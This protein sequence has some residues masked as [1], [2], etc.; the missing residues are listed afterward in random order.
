[1]PLACSNSEALD[2]H[3]TSGLLNAARLGGGVNRKHVYETMYTHDDNSTHL[4]RDQEKAE[5]Q[6]PDSLPKC[7]LK[8]D[9]AQ[10]SG[11]N[12]ARF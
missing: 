9:P 12:A 8:L 5:S 1:M 3:L 2:G 11:W 6:D 4:L 10:A 7:N